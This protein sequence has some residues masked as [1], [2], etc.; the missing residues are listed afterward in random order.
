MY[1]INPNRMLNLTNITLYRH[2]KITRNL[3]DIHILWFVLE[4]IIL[5]IWD[6]EEPF[7][8]IKVSQILSNLV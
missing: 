5:G 7:N 4:I 8:F 1:E 3:I 6:R 2:Y